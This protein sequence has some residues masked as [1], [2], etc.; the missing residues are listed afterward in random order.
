MR[1]RFDL[2]TSAFRGNSGIPEIR[3]SRN[4]EPGRWRPAL[5]EGRSPR[6]GSRHFRK[7]GAT[8]VGDERNQGARIGMPIQGQIFQMNSAMTASSSPLAGSPA[9]KNSLVRNW[10]LS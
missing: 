1:T 3:R 4:R 8:P 9:T 5:G 6:P 10:W 7:R 2:A